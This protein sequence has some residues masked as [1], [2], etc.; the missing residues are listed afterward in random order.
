[1][2]RIMKQVI[3]VC[4]ILAITVTM[5]TGCGSNTS[6]TTSPQSTD[7]SSEETSN[8]SH[9]RMAFLY[10][11]EEPADLQMVQDAV[12]KISISEINVEVEFV[13]ISLFQYGEQLNLMISGGEQLD[14][15]AAFPSLSSLYA[16]GQLMPLD[17]L[18]SEYGQGLT[19]EVGQDYLDGCRMGGEIYGVPIL[20]GFAYSSGICYS[21][22]LAEELDI[23]MS[24]V[25]SIDDLDAVL[26]EVH[27]KSP[28]IYA[29]AAKSASASLVNQMCSCDMLS[30]SI[31]VLMDP[32]NGT[33]IEL[34]YETETY[35]QLALK[36][37][38]WYE[39]GYIMKD[40]ASTS[41][42]LF[43]LIAA[44]KAFCGIT[45]Y[46][47]GIEIEQMSST[48]GKRVEVIPISDPLVSSTSVS[49][50]TM[51]IPITCAD[52]TA[53]MK[54]LNL[55]YTNADVLNLIDWGIEGVH[56]VKNED[57][58]IRYPEGVTAETSTY[59]I[60]TQF[61][62]ANELLSYVWEGND[63][64]IW[65]KKV[66]FDES[67]IISNALGFNFDS[68]SVKTQMTAVSNI[69]TQYEDALGNGTVDVNST[70]P[71]FIDDLKDAGIDDIIAE[72]QKQFDEFL[73]T[74]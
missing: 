11:G 41:E 47:P 31:G 28:D 9:I 27:E 46:T 25:A 68:S 22:D 52:T 40:Q 69:V 24:K 57:G 55:L 70:L 54:F 63:P 38:D 26:A 33:T 15:A 64:D 8:P 3:S 17:N 66:A 45:N 73:A 23:D 71:Q 39:K 50:S 60:G 56:Y 32:Q 30:D 29:I 2:K 16:K 74:K 42:T 59:N 12:N 4:C 48:N 6:N 10:I 43:S 18:L 72:K 49:V 13:P 34:L 5:L 62:N 44:D 19:E 51:C 65:A 7:V 58:T 14:V 53:A 36:V 20:C 21:V 67:A 37:R 35:K 1:M 61:M